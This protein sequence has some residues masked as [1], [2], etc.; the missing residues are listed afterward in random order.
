MFSTNADK[1]KQQLLKIEATTP[2]D[3]GYG[4]MIVL[5]VFM[6]G[7]FTWGVYVTYPIF[8]QPFMQKFGINLGDVTWI[9]GTHEI[10][11]A[12]GRKRYFNFFV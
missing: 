6:T 10:G 11:R 12:F 7:Y 5:A 8:Y 9:S 1:E 4:W 2:P 3:G